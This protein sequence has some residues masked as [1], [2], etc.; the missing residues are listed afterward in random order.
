[1]M[2][3][4]GYSFFQLL[5]PFGNEMLVKF[6]KMSQGWS[7]VVVVVDPNGITRQCYL[8]RICKFDVETTAELQPIPDQV[9]LTF[10]AQDT[11]AIAG[12]RYCSVT[13]SPT[14]PIGMRAYW[15]SWRWGLSWTPQQK[16][17]I[18]F[19]ETWSCGQV[20]TWPSS[21]RSDMRT[22]RLLWMLWLEFWAI[23][24]SSS[25]TSLRTVRGPS[26]Y[27]N[28]LSILSQHTHWV[29]WGR[30]LRGQAGMESTMRSQRSLCILGSRMNQGAS[31]MSPGR[32][33]SSGFCLL[34]S[35]T[36]Y[37]LGPRVV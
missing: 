5:K 32:W 22:R 26:S 37:N 14:A 3:I 35:Y 20:T 31:N 36:M 21:A 2:T 11:W 1:M 12:R 13:L 30:N 8:V 25:T 18:I 4:I 19:T 17:K 9:P 29:K 23:Y 6:Q 34:N 28:T 16:T 33:N 15:L 10:D 7:Q 27:R 24:A